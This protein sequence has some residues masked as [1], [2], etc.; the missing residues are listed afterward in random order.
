MLQQPVRPSAPFEAAA[1]EIH[2]LN[3]ARAQLL[4]L[5]AVD[6]VRRR[7]RDIL[8]QLTIATQARLALDIIVQNN[9]AL[10][11]GIDQATTA[12]VAALRVA[13]TAADAI[14][15]QR[16]VLDRIARVNAVAAHPNADPAAQHG[17]LQKAFGDV[18]QSIEALD[19]VRARALG[20]PTP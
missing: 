14:A 19:D 20:R 7:A 4:R 12:T 3:P 17:A 15:H 2:A 10:I 9:L 1:R 5:D 6:A 8:T 11:A 13:V 18:H 16:L